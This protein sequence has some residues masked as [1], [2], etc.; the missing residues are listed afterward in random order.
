MEVV[1]DRDMSAFFSD[2]SWQQAILTACE[3]IEKALPKENMAYWQ[4]VLLRPGSNGD[5]A[6]SQVFNGDEI[7]SLLKKASDS[8]GN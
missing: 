3:C 8:A 5:R 2:L 7:L 6:N 1:S 4:A